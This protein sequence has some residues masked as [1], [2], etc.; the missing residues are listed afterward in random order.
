VSKNTDNLDNLVNKI[1]I[2][3]NELVKDVDCNVMELRNAVTGLLE[4]ELEEYKA[5]GKT[6]VRAE[7]QYPRYLATTSPHSRILDRYRKAVEADEAAKL[8]LDESMDSALSE[9]RASTSNN[10]EKCQ[11]SADSSVTSD[12]EKENIKDEQLFVHPKSKKRELKRPEVVK[13]NILGSNSSL[14]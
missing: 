2:K 7:R 14:N 9:S 4:S 1:L 6:P 8:P 10:E 3:N 13:R 12:W 11:A 5:T